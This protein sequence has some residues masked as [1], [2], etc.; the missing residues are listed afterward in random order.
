MGEE[1]AMETA[2]EYA[3]RTA[4]E[5]A[6]GD[7]HLAAAQ[8]ALLDGSARRLLKQKFAQSG[9]DAEALGVA[10]GHPARVARRVVEGKENLNATNVAAYLKAM[11]AHGKPNPS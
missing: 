6:E 2:A 10:V 8:R 11:D 5:W 7:P 3:Y 1:Q 9:M 4:D